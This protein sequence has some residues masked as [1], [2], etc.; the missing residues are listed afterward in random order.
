MLATWDDHDY[1]KNDAGVE[2]GFKQ[3]SQ[4]IFLEFFDEAVDSPRWEREGVYAAPSFGPPNERVQII[5][6]DTRYHRDALRRR[7]KAEGEYGGPYGAGS[8]TILG[9]EQWEWLAQQLAVEADLRIICTSIQFV[10]E[11][12]H[13]ECWANYPSERARLMRLIEE[14]RANGVVFVS[15]DRHLIELSCYRDEGAP[16]PL[17]DFT[18]SGLNDATAPVDEPNRHRVG[19]VLRRANFGLL[20]VDWKRRLLTFEGRGAENELL[21]SQSVRLEDLRE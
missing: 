9:E 20:L 12:H 13:W 2:W 21:L 7:V 3:A 1:G 15:G 10:P 14:T 5:L 16:Y 17:W 18:S 19:D 4:E 6:L 11:E 8:G